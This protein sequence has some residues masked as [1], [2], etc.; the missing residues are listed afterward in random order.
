MSAAY[1]ADWQV[2]KDLNLQFCI[3]ET[4]YTFLKYTAMHKPLTVP[5]LMAISFM[6]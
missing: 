2:R 1:W 3:T 5:I 6:F 4:K